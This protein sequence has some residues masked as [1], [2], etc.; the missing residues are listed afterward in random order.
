VKA[1]KTVYVKLK[2][3]KAVVSVY[4]IYVC[5]NCVKTV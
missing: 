5:E 3:R 2:R 4:Y 1:A